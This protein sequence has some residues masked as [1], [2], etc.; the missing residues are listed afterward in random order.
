MSLFSII[1]LIKWILFNPV[2]SS[3]DCLLT[4]KIKTTMALVLSVLVLSVI[5][6]F[7]SRL[8]NPLT[9]LR[10]GKKRKKRALTR[11]ASEPIDPQDDPETAPRRPSLGS[12]LAAYTLLCAAGTLLYGR[13]GRCP[14]NRLV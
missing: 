7:L 3:P 12:A 9:I 6:S 2:R 5:V 1:R 4:A 10:T 14:I 13:Q 11:E 8:L